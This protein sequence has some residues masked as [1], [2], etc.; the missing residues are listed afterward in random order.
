MVLTM[1]D[2]IYENNG[3]V[4]LQISNMQKSP[5]KLLLKKLHQVQKTM[6]KSKQTV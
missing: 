5:Q 1:F 2:Y 6:A 4:E 3:E